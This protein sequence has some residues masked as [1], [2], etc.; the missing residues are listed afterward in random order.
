MRGLYDSVRRLVQSLETEGIDI[1][2]FGPS[3]QFSDEDVGRW[4]PVSV[5]IFKPV[6]P[7]AF[8]YSSLYMEALHEY[9]PEVVHTHG[10]WVYPSMAARRY[11]LETGATS[12]ISAHGMLD[13]WALN[14]SKWKKVIA[15]A[16]YEQAHLE[17]ANCLRALCTS[18]AES[19]RK[20]GLKNPIA[21]IPNGIDLPKGEPSV[22]AP[23]Q[24]CLEAGRKVMLYLGRLHPK[25]NLK[26]LVRAWK[27]SIGPETSEWLLVVCGWDQGGYENELKALATELEL[28]WEDLREQKSPGSPPPSILFTGPQFNEAKSAAYFNSHAFI[29]PSL[30]EGLPMVVLEAWAYGLP[31][32]M[33]PE[34][35]LPEGVAAQ[36]ALEIGQ[37]AK[38]ITTGLKTFFSLS[39][40]ERTEMGNY[41][42]KLIQ[43][44]FT[45]E[46]I[47]LEMRV[48][49]EWMLGAGNPPPCIWS[50]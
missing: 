42:R 47:A 26:E 43:A 9:A 20:I 34:C 15:Y 39:E 40:A 33:T 1:K 27:A 17:N 37:T 46:S 12:I 2:V 4:E 14:N 19:I 23:W 48:L 38:D 45:W 6:W 44:K 31:V 35:N 11:C 30:S 22:P 10:I 49:Y 36:A 21:V 29:L 8:G 3:D 5:S 25:K 32:L 28:A 13:P 16:L 50:K 18:E 24:G 7:E 41:G